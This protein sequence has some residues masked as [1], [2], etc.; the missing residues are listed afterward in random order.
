MPIPRDAIDRFL[1]AR[2]PIPLRVKGEK[3]EEL[4]WMIETM[5]RA[6]PVFKTLPRQ[7]QVEGLAFSLWAQTTLLLY[8]PRTGKTKLS[9][10]WLSYLKKIG[11][12]RRAVIVTHAPMA[13]DEWEGQLPIHTDLRVKVIRSED[14]FEDALYEALEEDADAVLFSIHTLQRNFTEKRLSRKKMNKLYAD[15]KCLEAVAACFDCAI[16]DEIHNYN[17][18]QSLWFELV[19]GIVGNAAWTL[20]L[21]G[22]PFGRNPYG[23]WAQCFLLDHGKALHP[24]YYFF[25]QAFGAQKYHHFARN[26]KVWKFDKAKMP[27]LKEKT[28]HMILSCTLEEVQDVNVL[29]GRV[30]LRM[31]PQ[32]QEA[33]NRVIDGAVARNIKGMQEI[34]NT[35]VQLRQIASGFTTYI[36]EKGNK[37][38]VEFLENSK[39]RWLEEFI[40]NIGGM[41]FLIV[42]EFIATGRMI[43]RLLDDLKIKY[44]WLYGGT[45]DK[46]RIKQDFQSGALQGVVLNWQTGGTSIDLSA[47]EYMCI[48]ESPSSSIART[49]VEARPLARGDRPFVL[50]DLICAPIEERILGFVAEG[51]SFVDELRASPV[52]TFKIL[53]AK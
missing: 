2:G 7:N 37:E 46:T 15:D 35:Y 44:G 45:K 23:L 22:T 31:S 19:A 41:Q 25:E 34:E 4:L 9:L 10:D 11:L 20:G 12:V 39:L 17:N 40:P 43:S 16:I 49:Q 36:D 38:V 13:T 30:N 8:S 6:K 26:K 27:L 42:T 53:R 5:G 29:A 50:D 18:P 32:Q 1:E 24:N 47:A 3:R 21:T 48:Y 14:A 52:D 28:A 51:K 33:Y